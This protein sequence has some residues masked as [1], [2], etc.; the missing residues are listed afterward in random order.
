M[1]IEQQPILGRRSSTVGRFTVISKDPSTLARAKSQKLSS[2]S[3]TSSMS[4]ITTSEE[5]AAYSKMRNLFIYNNKHERR[6]SP[7]DSDET[8]ETL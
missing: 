6:V 3:S 7:V 8:I 2:G 1:T 5:D 4:A